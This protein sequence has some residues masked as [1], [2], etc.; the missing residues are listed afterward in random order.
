MK[1][2]EERIK[3]SY[4]KA[5][6]MR[7]ARYRIQ[8]LCTIAVCACLVIAL[9]L[10]LFIPINHPAHSLSAYEDSEYYSVISK[11][12]KLT[13]DE[14]EYKNYYQKWFGNFNL[15][16]LSGCGAKGNYDDAP[17]V[18]ESNGN[19]VEVTDNQVYG[20][21]EGD[22]FK[23]TDKYIF[24]I[25]ENNILKIYSIAQEHSEEA[26]QFEISPENGTSFKGYAANTEMYLNADGTTV[27]LVTPAYS[28]A[29]GILY[30]EFINIDVSDLS[31]IK[32]SG[33]LYVS[34]KYISSRHTDAGYLLITQFTVG[35]PDFSD[36]KSFLPQAGTLGNLESFASDQIICPETPDYARYT[37]IC[38]LD[39]ELN[40]KGTCAFLSYSQNVYV[41]EENVYTI[42]NYTEPDYEVNGTMY[43][44]ES[45]SE[46]SRVSY[47]DGLEYKGSTVITGSVLN[48]YSLDEYNGIL[49]VAASTSYV[50]QRNT[51][52]DYYPDAV[53]SIM[54]ASVYCIDITDG[55]IVGVLENFA[56]N[57]EQVKS[58]RFDKNTAYVCTAV[59]FSDPVFVI[60]LSDFNDITYSDTGTITGYS[61][62]L[63]TFKNGTLLGIGYGDSSSVL[64]IELYR[65][66]PEGVISEAAYTR[67][68][69]FS[70][71]YK[72]Y[73][74]DA[75]SGLIGLAVYDWYYG[76]SYILLRY[77]GY[78][79]NVIR[80]VNLK[81]GDPACVRAT[82]IDGW[83]Y[84]VDGNGIHVTNTDG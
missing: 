35:T 12:D 58:A 11:I 29:D 4:E 45:R 66:T 46:I 84:V 54:S 30:T 27:T 2:Y 42:R 69:Y 21:T 56:P 52:E 41:S 74:I 10:V 44:N 40:L 31:D 23:R 1:N 36:E 50:K 5:E 61:L 70:S 19:Y 81:E 51:G 43:Y 64:K 6:N 20:V 79:L 28:T 32:I 39:D 14:P 3:S 60:D 7:T 63:R 82:C 78:N 80:E 77:D 26:A 38:N 47:T 34:G 13:Y 71:T 37:V 24:Y 8:T 55:G 17:A 18:E 48:S 62:A 75:E 67:S 72:S 65:E 22:L 57:G 53:T 76:H 73:Y 68:A 15:L 25:T 9:A 16:S 49:R 59:E 83:L 33:R